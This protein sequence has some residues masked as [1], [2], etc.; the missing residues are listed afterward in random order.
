MALNRSSSQ[1]NMNDLHPDNPIHSIEMSDIWKQFSDVVAN[2]GV[3]LQLHAGEVH[4]LLGENGAGKTTLMK[5][6]SG[7]YRPD[8]GSVLINGQ[9]VEFSSPA[10][11]MRA[12]IGIV[13]QHFHLIETMTAAE[14]IHLGWND[15]PWVISNRKLIERM[16]AINRKFGM[17][18]DTSAKVWQLSVGEQ[19]R[20]EIL[21]VLA[22][23]A[24]VLILDEPTAVLTPQEAD[25]LFQVMH[26]LAA[27]GRIIVF[28]SHKLD[29]VCKV[30]DRVTILRKGMNIETCQTCDCTPRSLARM[31]I[32][33]DLISRQNRSKNTADID[34][35]ELRGVSALNDRGLIA[36]KDINLKLKSGEILGIAGVAGNGQRELAELIAGLRPV[37]QGQMLLKGV[38]RTGDSPSDLALDG[39]GHVPE[40]RY[41][42]GL[43]LE[44]TI[45]ENAIMRNY[46][47]HPISRAGFQNKIEA[48]RFTNLLV[49]QSDVRT[50][51]IQVPVQNLSGG[52]QQ[53]LLVTREMHTA[54]S[55]LIAVHPTRG[56]D[57]AATENVRN[58]LVHYRNNGGGVLLIS[59]D[60]DEVLLM[61]DRILVIYEG[62]IMGEF[63]AAYVDK[64]DKEEI[65][66]QM[67]GKRKGIKT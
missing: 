42:M 19:Q 39:I 20:V 47:T 10:A 17:K 23:G 55:V 8:A 58:F 62:Q 3:D 18:V 14:N 31:M 34:A 56:L 25:E 67:G 2:H 1:E 11:A 7:Y 51:G 37:T 63:D 12:G 36:L 38:D 46:K 24:K 60:L 21:R 26:S 65:G 9:R 35:L 59:E 45:M 32:G 41:N 5:I 40:D 16:E 50:S 4:A 48:E 49:E 30:S 54:T 57:V 61:S 27:T 66:L 15:T 43:V 29:E 44:M 52:N 6:L 64:V 33:Y 22:R 28:I 53:K 13:H